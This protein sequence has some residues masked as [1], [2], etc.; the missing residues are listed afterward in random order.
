MITVTLYED[1]DGND[2]F[3]VHHTIPD[4]NGEPTV[5]DVT[6]HHEVFAVSLSDGRQA[7]AV[8]RKEKT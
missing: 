2:K 5:H 6:E 4:E 1:D 7:W 8:A 3:Q